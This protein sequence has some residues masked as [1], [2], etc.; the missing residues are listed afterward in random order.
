MFCHTYSEV[1]AVEEKYGSSTL[2]LLIDP[3]SCPFLWQQTNSPDNDTA[4]L[5]KKRITF[6]N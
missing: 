1:N 3:L 6:F 5:L 4:H 2:C